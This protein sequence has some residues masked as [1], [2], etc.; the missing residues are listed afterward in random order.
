M[1]TND[2]LHLNEKQIDRW[3]AEFKSLSP[4]N[5]LFRFYDLFHHSEVM[6]T[7]S[8][9]TTSALLVHLVSYA[10]PNQTIFF[11]DTGYHFDETLEYK[12]RLS[13][14]YGLNVADVHPDEILHKQTREQELWKSDPNLC[15]QINKVMALEKLRTQ[16]K[17]WI[18]GLMSWQ[19]NHRSE[20]QIFDYRRGILKFYPLI[21]MTE[22]ERDA[23]FAKLD[24]PKHPLS[25]KGY[26][27]IGCQQCTVPGDGRSGRWNNSPKTECGL[28]L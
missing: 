23:A 3:N 8:F 17:V 25:F 1:A 15:C 12:E 28:H 2:M 6:L 16:Y 11:I 5:R 22:S 19:S 20:L 9:A 27:S 7:S 18:S 10:E 26:G 14:E 13:D 24:L 4:A 21:D